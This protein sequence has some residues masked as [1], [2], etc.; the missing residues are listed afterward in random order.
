MTGSLEVAPC[1]AHEWRQKFDTEEREPGK[2]PFQGFHPT[3]VQWGSL[4]LLFG[5]IGKA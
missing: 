5:Q 4:T 2:Q 3:H 1:K